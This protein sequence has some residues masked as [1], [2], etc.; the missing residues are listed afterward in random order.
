ML[1]NID[2]LYR[3]DVQK[4]LRWLSFARR[5]IHLDE[6]VDALAVDFACD[7]PTFDPDE[8]YADSRDIITRC[9]SLVSISGSPGEKCFLKLAHL[10]VKEYLISDRIRCTN[11]CCG[12]GR[13]Q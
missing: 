6:M 12:G 5:P 9:S 1:V 4:V 2:E 3:E 8:R 10:S 13:C 11:V 7:C